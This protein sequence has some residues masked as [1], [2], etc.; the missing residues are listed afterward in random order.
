MWIADHARERP[1]APAYIFAGTGE[2]LTWRDLNERSMRLARLLARHG[3]GYGEHFAFLLENG[4]RFVEGC[5]AG[6]RSGL[7]YTPISTR[8]T[9]A[10]VAHVL[11][12]CGAR[13][14]IT[15]SA[16]AEVAGPLADLIPPTVE[17][18][19]VVGGPLAG[20]EDYE[21][22]L[23]AEPAEPLP[24]EWEGQSMLYSGGTTG[25]PKG[26]KPFL[27]KRPAGEPMVPVEFYSAMYRVP[28]DAVVLLT[29]P[30]YHNAQ[31]QVLLYSGRRGDTQVI[32]ERFD[33][34]ATLAAIERYRV[35]FAQFVPAMFVRM[36]K[37]PEEVRS[38]Y[39]V[40]SLKVAVHGAAPCPVEI[41][42]K[43]IDWWGPV[44]LEYYGA[45]E[46]VGGSFIDSHDWL[47][48]P[49]SVGRSA[50]GPVHVL[51][52]AGNELP[53]GQPG[54]LYFEPPSFLAFGYHKDPTKTA[55]A[56]EK[57]GW[58][59]VGDVGYVDAE[60]Y[61]YLTDRASF[62]IIS[63]G[64]NIFPQEAENVLINHPAVFDCGVIGVPHP[65]MGEEV[66]AVVSLV[67][68]AAP[69]PELEQELIQYCRDRLAHYKCPK[70]V[71]FAPA[72]PRSETGKLF[73]REL[74]APYWAGR[75]KSV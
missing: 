31:V 38:R 54:L 42:R 52:E 20:Y 62:T 55:A 30:L 72:L 60:G 56:T 61:M 1:D 43:M 24:E 74:R 28:D 59:T 27:M 8:F 50:L 68:G 58:V 35:S 40:S 33:P 37:L 2:T 25:L 7:F 19:L 70:S 41:K 64:V 75:E 6:Q 9:P 46:P 53:P 49:G 45:T 65:E 12:D 57:H 29:A 26:V 73:K 63:G 22:A 14:F 47:A 51:D 15:S 39:D 66:K 32:M 67:P 34:E 16:M 11:A 69:S 44:L 13:V 23:A 36:L 10:E 4:L 3:L 21:T 17:R 5:W 71:D 48:H 18:R